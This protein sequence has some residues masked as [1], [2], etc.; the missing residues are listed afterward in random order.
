MKISFYQTNRYRSNYQCER[1][2]ADLCSLSIAL[3]KVG[4]TRNRQR[5]NSL[6][7]AMRPLSI[8]L[9]KPNFHVS[10]SH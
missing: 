8:G 6:T 5:S 9:I 3:T 10:V 7:V 2:G 4:N 1:L